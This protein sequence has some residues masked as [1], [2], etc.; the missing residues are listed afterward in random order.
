MQDLNVERPN[1]LELSKILRSLQDKVPRLWR[2]AVRRKRATPPWTLRHA[3]G[4]GKLQ[5]RPSPPGQSKIL[6]VCQGFSELII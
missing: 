1:G 5:S 6:V 4:P 3:G 2:E